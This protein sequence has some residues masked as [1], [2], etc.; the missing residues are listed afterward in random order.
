MMWT[1]RRAQQF[2]LWT[3]WS[4][5]SVTLL[6][7]RYLCCS[8]VF[9]RSLKLVT[10]LMTKVDRTIVVKGEW[11]EVAFAVRKDG[12]KPGGE[13]LNFLKSK[14]WPQPGI[15]LP[16]EAQPAFYFQ[17]IS[18]L[19]DLADGI[20]LEAGRHNRLRSGIWEL[21]RDAVRLT[22]F[23]TDGRG[24]YVAK[25]GATKEDFDGSLQ[26]QLLTEELDEFV[27]VGFAFTKVSQMTPQSDILEAL[28]VREEDL[29][30]DQAG[31]E[32]EN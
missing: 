14:M 12:S 9:V 18:D 3:T 13:C 22:F 17:L 7:S 28:R 11:L 21:K 30:H 15:E 2:S 26:R 31:P 25:N 5:A 6:Q 20:D 4:K 8:S 29:K 24:G 10:L 16:D 23:D 27:R 19:R 1:L 32:T